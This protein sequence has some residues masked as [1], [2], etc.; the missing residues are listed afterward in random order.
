MS[1]DASGT[2]EERSVAAVHRALRERGQTVCVAESLTGGQLAAL[3]SG[4]AG[5]SATFT[6]AVV[7]YAS[8]VKRELLDVTAAQVVSADAA[9]QMAGRARTILGADWALSTTGVAG[10][11]LQ[12]G[13][14]VGTV[15]IALAGPQGV[16]CAR[17]SLVGDRSAIRAA[18]CVAAVELLLAEVAGG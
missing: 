3:L 2:A 13:K 17:L 7:A 8:E 9:S 14:P 15:F 18:T 10:P 12:E 1:T 6:G 4:E 16:R 5:A 11:D